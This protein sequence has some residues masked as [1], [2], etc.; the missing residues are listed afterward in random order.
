M[1]RGCF[2]TSIKGTFVTNGRGMY[3]SKLPRFSRRCKSLC[4]LPLTFPAAPMW[5]NRSMAGRGATLQAA[6]AIVC[7]MSA[8]MNPKYHNSNNTSTSASPSSGPV[9][10]TDPWLAEGPVSNDPLGSEM[11]ANRCFLPPSPRKDMPRFIA[12]SHTWLEDAN[13]YDKPTDRRTDPHKDRQSSL[14]HASLCVCLR[15]HACVR[16]VVMHAIRA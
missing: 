10:P 6:F 2:A 15:L 16:D 1:F 3:V 12:L 7:N 14:P 8:L 13:T 5:D 4:A 11:L 9:P